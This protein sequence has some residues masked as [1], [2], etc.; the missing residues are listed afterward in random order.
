MHL[1]FNSLNEAFENLLN[2]I[3]VSNR[4]KVTQ[5]RNGEVRKFTEPVLLT[6]LSPRTRVMLWKGRKANPFFHVYEAM[7]ML[8]G[9]NDLK[10][11]T[12]FVKTFSD[13]SDDGETINGAYG[14][15]WRSA[16]VGETD[17]ED[18]SEKTLCSLNFGGGDS[19]VRVDQLK[20]LLDLLHQQKNTRRAV[21]TMWNVVDDLLKTLY[22]RDVCCNLNVMFSISFEKCPSCK[23]LKDNC[24]KCCHRATNELRE[25][26]S[27]LDMTV[28]NRSNDLILG[29]LGANYV[30][31]TFLQEYLAMLLGLEV[32]KYHHFTNDLHIYT[33]GPHPSIK[34][35]LEV[36]PR[37]RYST[38]N[39]ISET[40]R[41]LDYDK[42]IPLMTHHNPKCFDDILTK[43]R[44]VDE[45]IATFVDNP[46]GKVTYS[47]SPFLEL[48]AKPMMAVHENWTKYRNIRQASELALDIEALDWYDA[49]IDWLETRK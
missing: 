49:V 44:Y 4:V 22:S 17:L 12:Q 30:H 1:V 10:S 38:D 48:V 7:W 37:L 13:F 43:Q 15:R 28:T 2:R 5:T 21:L 19:G 36:K 45:D 3:D 27:K 40:N 29:M 33:G 41:V 14:Y 20:V 42:I 39:V 16:G 31:F 25:I 26:P 24:T 47:Y 34:D 32:G 11:L 23:G 8:A 6:Y 46:Y 9:R 35:L 18:F